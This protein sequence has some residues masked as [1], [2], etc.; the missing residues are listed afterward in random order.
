MI[1]FKCTQ[2]DK[3]LD[4]LFLFVYVSRISLDQDIICTIVMVFLVEIF[5]RRTPLCILQ[6]GHPPLGWQDTAAYLV[7]PVLLVLSQYVSMEIMKPPQVS[8]HI[9]PNNSFLLCCTDIL[10]LFC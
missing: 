2:W 6:D 10:I 7:L 8:S 5:H 3:H 9:T 4:F 1:L